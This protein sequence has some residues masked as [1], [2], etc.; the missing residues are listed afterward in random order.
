MRSTRAKED[1]CP[2]SPPLLPPPPPGDR[3]APRPLPGA[4]RGAPRL[5]DT[6]GDTDTVALRVVGPARDTGPDEPATPLCR[7]GQSANKP[8]CDGTHRKVEFQADDRET[9]AYADR[10]KAY[11]GTDVVVRDDR[12]ICVHA[13]FCG[14]KA[15]NVWKMVGGSSATETRSL[16]IAMIERCPSGA[17]T[18]AIGDAVEPA[19]PVQVGVVPNGPLVVTGGM[20]VQAGDAALEVRNRVTLCRCGP[21]ANKPLCDGTPQGGRLH[22][23]VSLAARRGRGAPAPGATSD[24]V[25]G[26]RNR[27]G[28]PDSRRRPPR[29]RP[30]TPGTRSHI[31][32][33]QR[34]QDSSG[35]PH[36]DATH[37]GA[38]DHSWRQEPHRGGHRRRE[39]AA[40]RPRRSGQDAAV[41]KLTF[42][43]RRRPELSRE[44]FQRYWFEVHGPLVRERAEL[45]GIRR[46]VQLH[47]A[48]LGGLHR[49]MQARNG[50]APEPF[51]GV[52]ELWFD[53]VES[54]TAARS[55]AATAAAAELL[56]DERTFIDLPHSPMWLAEERQ[57]WP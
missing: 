36:R 7:C 50:G 29:P 42:A 41:I 13:G 37:P 33:G 3:A 15:T 17:L 21:S 18:Y 52:A 49:A 34:H 48:D 35:L 46:Y 10:S 28:R 6:G 9:G 24:V 11:E 44:E 32:C 51:D 19:L 38:A 25:S 2:T 4:V 45:L 8:F 31:A 47:T 39:L 14:T 40:T 30:R 1:P 26:A 27:P 5:P 23:P 12:S 22:R 57:I 43:L 16:M 56:A 55:E 53:D 54:F 20:A